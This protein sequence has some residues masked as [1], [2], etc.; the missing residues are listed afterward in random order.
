MSILFPSFHA[1]EGSTG[2][3]G[4]V[5][6]LLLSSAALLLPSLRYVS[7]LRVHVRESFE[8]GGA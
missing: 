8:L 3:R 7:V 1:Q 5:L 2:P 6:E 4:G